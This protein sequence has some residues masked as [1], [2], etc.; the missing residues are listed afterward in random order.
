MFLHSL[1][2]KALTAAITVACGTGFLLFGYDQGVFGGLLSN[3]A[4]LR[5]FKNPDAT[6]Q[7]QIVSTYDLGCI[8]GAISTIFFGDKIGRRRTIVLGCLFVMVGG[9][10]QSASYGLAQ[11]IVGR[12]VAGVGTGISRFWGRVPSVLRMCCDCSTSHGKFYIE[13]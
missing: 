2:G 10:I 4:F 9:T 1:Q 8:M 3:L 12:I 5:V 6:I 13:Q 11:M 7:G